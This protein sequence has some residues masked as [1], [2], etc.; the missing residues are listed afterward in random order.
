MKEDLISK[1]VDIVKSKKGTNAERNYY[2]KDNIIR[3][4]F[5]QDYSNTDFVGQ[6]LPKITKGENGEKDKVE[7]I[8][9]NFCNPW[10]K[11]KHR[12]KRLT[13]TRQLEKYKTFLADGGEIYFK[14]DDD[15]LFDAS[16]IYFE[17]SGFDIIKKIYDLHQVA[18]ESKIVDFID[19]EYFDCGHGIHN[20]KK[21]EF[22]P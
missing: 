7:R 5:Y 6:I 19:V 9:I 15:E 17:E 20:E 13:H 2:E 12:K 18:A 1:N 14:T 3:T 8:Y 21:K 16:L 22:L 11:G 10:P 4:T